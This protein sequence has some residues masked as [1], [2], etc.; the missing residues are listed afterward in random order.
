MKVLINHKVIREDLH[1][2]MFYINISKFSSL[3]S[4]HNVTNSDLYLPLPDFTSNAQTIYLDPLSQRKEILKET[5]GKSGVYC[6]I[7]RLNGNYYI[8]SS[9]NL[10]NRLNDYF[11]PWYY[12]DRLNLVIVRA[13]K[14]YGLGNFALVILE[15]TKP[16]DTLPREQY[17]LD[18]L[19]PEY[20]ILDTA[21]NSLGYK[22]TPE[23]IEKM[24]SKALGRKH[25]EEVRKTM[26]E[27]RR[28]ENNNFYGKNHSEESLVKLREIAKNRSK[29]PRPGLLVEVTDLENNKRIIYTSIRAAARSLGCNVSTLLSRESRA[30][31]KPYKGK[32]VITI[33][34]P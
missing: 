5:N 28:G 22:Q 34:R 7:N 3:S 10:N 20:N 1:L 32:Y 18:T 2:S 15:V 4:N 23:S 31:K 17:Y 19:E 11:Q 33:N 24:R 16:E 30:S 13:I 12:K 25:S 6:W 27:N 21:G 14:K 8:G 29:D 9:I 26:S